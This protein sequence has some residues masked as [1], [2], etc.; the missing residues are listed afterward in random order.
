MM[1]LLDT[2]ATMD[3]C[4]ADLG[5]TVE[6][7]QLITPLTG[8]S[9]L[10]IRYAVDNGAFSAF[11]ERRFLAILE[12]D[13]PHR[14]NCI[15]VAVPDV[16]GSARRTL[17]V[18]DHWFP[19]LNSWPCAFVA[20]DGIEDMTIPWAVMDAVFIGGSTEWKT[21]RHAVAVAKA[22]RAMGKWVHVGRVNTP[23]RF[24]A[25]ADLADSVDGTGVGRYSH[26]R[27]DLTSP[28]L[29][30]GVDAISAVPE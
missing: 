16:V 24:S 12:R 1:V 27:V 4:R 19:R 30:D 25:W 20:Q 23:G 13:R 15:F 18:W 10:G 3:E 26:M 6:V 22:A 21:S 8:R 14:G 11:E 7:G 5:P 2:S 9:N 28:G 29:L 17:E